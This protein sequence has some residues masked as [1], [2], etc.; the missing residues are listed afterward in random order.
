[1]R[2]IVTSVGSVD[3]AATSSTLF[4][5]HGSTEAWNWVAI[6]VRSWVTQERRK[7]GF[8]SRGHDVFPTARLLVSRSP[9]H[10][11]DVHQQPLRESVLAHNVTRK[12]TSRRRQVEVAI[13]E[14]SLNHR[15]PYVQLSA[16]LLD[17][18]GLSVQRYVPAVARLHLLPVR[19]WSSGTSLLYQL[20][21]ADTVIPQTVAKL[22]TCYDTC[23]PRY[24]VAKPRSRRFN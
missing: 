17:R 8:H 13:F 19:K 14:P 16:K 7:V 2:E 12:R 23:R 4:T 15:A 6:G 11:Y 1:M 21:S 10:P 3:L 22:S 5:S 9:I 18:N 20:K 24:V